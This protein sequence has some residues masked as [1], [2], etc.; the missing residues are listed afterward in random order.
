MVLFAS[1][2]AL[3]FKVVKIVYL[4]VVEAWLP[5]LSV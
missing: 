5:S 1:V 3:E 4:A 2:T